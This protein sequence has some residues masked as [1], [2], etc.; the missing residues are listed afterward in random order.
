MD[1]V[2]P[3]KKTRLFCYREWTGNILLALLFLGFAHRFAVHFIETR[4]LSSLLI[5]L[6]ES[7][8]IILLI[9]RRLP[10]SVSFNLEDWLFAFGGTW[11]ILLCNPAGRNDFLIGQILLCTGALMQMGSFLSLNRSLGDCS[12]Q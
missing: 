9:I 7:I 3:I 10:S 6:I 8:V 12:R 1:R 4:Q 2:R 5:L 11:L